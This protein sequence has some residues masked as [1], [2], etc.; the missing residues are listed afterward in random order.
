V[1]K[2]NTALLFPKLVFVDFMKNQCMQRASGMAYATLLALVPILTLSFGLFAQFGQFSKVEAF[3][4]D[5]VLAH[6]IPSTSNTLYDT[7]ST[8]LDQFMA[9]AMAINIV[10]VICLA[11][12]SVS[13]FATVEN[14]FNTVWR[15][16]RH[17]TFFARY[18]A[19]CGILL[20]IPLL[21]GGSVY[22]SSMFNIHSLWEPFPLMGRIAY[23]LLPLLLTWGGFILF[24]QLVPFIKVQWGPSILGG[25]VAGTLWEIAK[26]GYG[27]YVS[28]AVSYSVIYGSLGSLLLFLVWL[29]LTWAIVLLG[30]E[31]CYVGQNFESLASNGDLRKR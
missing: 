29:Y 18:N 4:K 2:V 15:I 14:S 10:G 3:F 5:K 8:Y 1:S 11:F 22:L 6:F 13:L 16:T 17:R 21:I 19:F 12:I 20:G 26:F 30:V 7:V 23:T 9:N 31:I 27:I 25:I 28:K 24:Y